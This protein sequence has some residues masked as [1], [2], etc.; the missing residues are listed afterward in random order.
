MKSILVGT[1]LVPLIVAPS[2]AQ[3][4]DHHY[5]GGPK[6]EV[7]HHVGPL[8]TQGSTTGQG[9]SSQKGQHHYQGGPQ[10][11]VPHHVGDQPSS[12]QK[13]AKRK[14]KQKRKSS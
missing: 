1:L 12:K 7:P 9:Q 14:A 8:S 10:S 11:N 6:T 13:P 5:Q 3:R 4:A 2:A